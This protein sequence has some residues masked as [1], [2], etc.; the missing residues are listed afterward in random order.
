MK[1]MY[2][3]HTMSRLQVEDRKQDNQS[4]LAKHACAQG[5]LIIST[6]KG[7]LARVGSINFKRFWISRDFHRHQQE[8]SMSV[9]NLKHA[10]IQKRDCLLPRPII[11]QNRKEHRLSTPMLKT[12]STK[13]FKPQLQGC[14]IFTLLLLVVIVSSFAYLSLISQPS[15]GFL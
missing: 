14:P 3:M 7:L 11:L 2:I 12:C 10:K 15:L 5:V 13:V 4:T 9:L 1:Y 8:V 6:G